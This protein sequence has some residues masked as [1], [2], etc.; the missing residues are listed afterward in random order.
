MTMARGNGTKSG[1]GASTSRNERGTF[2]LSIILGKRQ[3]S[4]RA[5]G[6][7]LNQFLVAGCN[8]RLDA[9]YFLEQERICTELTGGV[10]KPNCRY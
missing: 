2:R 6:G 3:G 9:A 5:G 7:Y 10:R 1:S 4:Y 8:S